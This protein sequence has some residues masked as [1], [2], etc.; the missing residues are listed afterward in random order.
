MTTRGSTRYPYPQPF[1]KEIIPRLL[2]AYL[3]RTVRVETGGS[4]ANIPLDGALVALFA[5]HSG[6]VEPVVIDEWFKRVGRTPAVWVTKREN[7]AIPRILVGD[8]L[9][10]L[11]RGSP[12]PSKVRAIY[13]IL[14]Q[15]DALIATSIEG[16]RFGNPEDRKDLLTL[17]PFKTGM[18]RIAV[19]AQVPLLPVVVLGAERVSPWLDEIWRE[20][21][22]PAAFARVQRLRA[23][24]QPVAVRFH[25]PYRG[26]IGEGRDLGGKGIRESAALHA[27]RLGKVFR[28][29]ILELRPDYPLGTVP[30]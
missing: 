7:L 23:D 17:G 3:A 1:W 26:H 18:V 30:T 12:E 2:E 9:I 22:I 25:P 21:G 4:E 11:D 24:P 8:R 6:W 15:P 5:P 27:H 20:Q 14:E 13:Q 19:R 10:C 29:K 28:A 16:S